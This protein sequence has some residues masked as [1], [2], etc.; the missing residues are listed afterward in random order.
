TAD[1][2]VLTIRVGQLSVLLVRRGRPPYQGRWA[3]PGGFVR[4]DE[5]LEAAALRQLSAET[6]LGGAALHLEQLRTYGAPDRDPRAR[7]VSVAHLGLMPDL[8]APSSQGGGG[9]A[10]AR[11]WPVADLGTPDGP[12]LAF[13]HSDIVAEG[14]ERARA[15]LEYTPLATAFVEQP[16]TLA[17]LRRIYEAV[18]GTPVHPANFRRKVLSTEGFVIPLGQT[19]PAGPEGGRPADLY[20]PGPAQLLHPAMLRPVPELVEVDGEPETGEL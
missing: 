3:L 10:S 12:E 2:V 14:V 7:V 13:D 11:F 15:K 19:A 9:A 5:D 4:P 18:W 8:P 20:R 1:I 17:E 16:F 6:G